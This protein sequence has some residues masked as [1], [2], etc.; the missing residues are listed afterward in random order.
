MFAFAGW[1]ITDMASFSNAL[2]STTSI[3]ALEDT[4]CLQLTCR[5]FDQ[6]L[7]EIPKLERYFRILMQNAY[8]REQQ[9]VRETISLPAAERYTQLID[10]YPQL[11][12]RVSQKNVASYLGI[13]PQALST[14]RRKRKER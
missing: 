12:Q 10:R 13:T 14:L 9:R 5:Q 6:I 1:W 2:P 7:T 3:V 11:E 8:I 4:E